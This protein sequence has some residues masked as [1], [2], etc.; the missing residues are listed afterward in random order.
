MPIIS[1]SESSFF[2]QFKRSLSDIADIFQ[3][4]KPK[5]RVALVSL[6]FVILV[7]PITLFT[8]RHQTRTRSDAAYQIYQS[9]P[10]KRPILYVDL[11]IDRI[12]SKVIVDG[13]SKG[14]G[15]VP[16]YKGVGLD[17]MKVTLTKNGA[18]QTLSIPLPV[19]EV[20]APPRK[21]NAYLAYPRRKLDVFKYPIILP[22]DE[23]TTVSINKQ[24]TN[25]TV[26]KLSTQKFTIP[27]STTPSTSLI[28]EG[29]SKTLS[30]QALAV[31]ESASSY[32]VETI[33]DGDPMITDPLKTLDIIFVSS[34][35]DETQYELFRAFTLQ[36]ADALIGF[37]SYPGKAP[38]NS[39][40]QIIKVR[41]LVSPNFF[42]S[43][44][45]SGNA[46]VRTD[47]VIKTLAAL[48]IPYDQIS[49][50][51]DE[52]GRSWATLGGGYNVL[53]RTWGPP[54]RSLLFAHE[55]G[56]SFG[57][58]LDEYIEYSGSSGELSTYDRNCKE[59][60]DESWVNNSPGGAY[61]GC[62]YVWNLYKPE[63]DS[64]MS[65]IDESINF[66]A[67]SIYLLEQALS[68]YTKNEISYL[69]NPS[70]L[71]LS[72][73]LAYPDYPPY[74]SLTISTLGLG[75]GSFQSN[76]NPSQNWLVAG[77]MNGGIPGWMSFHANPQGLTKGVY[78]SNLTVNI[79]SPVS[80]TYSLPIKLFVGD[81]RDTGAVAITKPLNHQSFV[82]GSQI[83]FE[84]SASNSAPG[85]RRVELYDLIPG[86]Y[87]SEIFMSKTKG[88]FTTIWNTGDNSSVSAYKG[89]HTFTAKAIRYFGAPIESSKT[90]VEIVAKPGSICLAP[91]ESCSATRTSNA[92]YRGS[93]T[94]STQSQPFCCP[95][96]SPSP[97]P[98]PSIVPSITLSPTPTTS[99][100]PIPPTPTP[101]IGVSNGNFESGSNAKGIPF[102]WIGINT[103]D[104]TDMLAG[105]EYHSYSHSFRMTG[106][107]VG[108]KTKILEQD[109]TNYL[110]PKGK[111][112]T[113]SVWNKLNS[114]PSGGTIVATVF[115][116]NK[117][118][119]KTNYKIPFSITHVGW[120]YQEKCFILANDVVRLRVRLKYSGVGARTF[121]DD[122]QISF[123][124]SCPTYTPPAAPDIDD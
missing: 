36:Q 57:A 19:E 81:S 27:S 20:Y 64:L 74:A 60:P 75:A 59:D 43:K 10:L 72:Q 80:K 30:I 107:K 28:S 96:V 26:N 116:N 98:Y 54:E 73:D 53:F 105:G 85:I 15:F 3:I 65:V 111:I 21:K 87:Y 121:F 50:V 103:V 17:T 124:K 67:P 24:F 62:N 91:Y 70:R 32:S 92:C 45:T 108:A 34:G 13:L 78:T 89:I 106:L 79:D 114:P 11:T 120:L 113:L 76:F 29:S 5:H 33:F 71:F 31:K 88:P 14:T 4:V 22:Y 42:H 69:F 97:T 117:D 46:N 115:A 99:P 41:R 118:G 109:V 8:L 122:V 6:L 40:K 23:G 61:L 102:S 100:T 58:L 94:C 95:P 38:F 123:P 86:G 18:T 35:F 101:T 82:S 49:I 68:P 7:L 83:Q 52:D 1:E 47:E 93:D 77:Q 104:L 56:H 63:K 90:E 25:K 2:A 16:D 110:I 112:F 48:G 51:L 119:T 9:S 44:D 66:N 37:S 12:N 39:N 55:F 84:I